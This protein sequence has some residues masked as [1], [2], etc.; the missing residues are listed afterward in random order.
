MY[1]IYFNLK[2]FDLNCLNQV[3][4]FLL[5][6]FC[7]FNLN[8]PKQKRKPTRLKKITV[9]RSPHIDKKSREHFQILSHKKTI[10]LTLFNEKFF[11]LVLEII[12]NLKLIGIELE[13]LIEFS[14]FY[15]NKTT[16]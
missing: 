13:L 14:T 16:V 7:F 2:S 5:S 8:Q 10:I 4:T 11:F 3:E 12:K 6:L 15:E 9:L 1:K